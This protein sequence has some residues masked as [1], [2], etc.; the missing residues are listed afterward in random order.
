MKLDQ[1]TEVLIDVRHC[2]VVCIDEFHFH[3]HVGS[4][5][6]T[7]P[8]HSQEWLS[9]FLKPGGEVMEHANV[10]KPVSHR[11]PQGLRV[12]SVFQAESLGMGY[13]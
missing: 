7:C 12:G 13:A 9:W 10:R 8:S 5:C 6:I 2:F 1:I 4:M 3:D 11:Y